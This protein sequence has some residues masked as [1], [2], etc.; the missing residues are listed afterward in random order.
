MILT[1]AEDREIRLH[2]LTN[3]ETVQVWSCCNGRVKRLAV[4]DRSPYLT[5]SASEDGCIRY[6]NNSLKMK[7][8]HG[9]WLNF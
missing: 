3:F 8:G 4:S 2:D 1:G 7:T 6:N 9:L 5:W